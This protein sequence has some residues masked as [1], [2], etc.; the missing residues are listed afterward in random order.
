MTK[1][2]L[3]EIFHLLVDR[4]EGAALVNLAIA[5]TM[6]V[7]VSAMKILTEILNKCEKFII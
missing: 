6:N 2:Y 5:D 3:L 1:G 7:S 4:E